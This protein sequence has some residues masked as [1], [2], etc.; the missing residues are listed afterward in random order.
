MSAVAAGTA[1]Y[2]GVHALECGTGRV[3]PADVGGEG[4]AGG[5]RNVSEPVVFWIGAGFGNKPLQVEGLNDGAGGR[6]AE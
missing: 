1:E 6:V 5:D 4:S 2:A 3:P